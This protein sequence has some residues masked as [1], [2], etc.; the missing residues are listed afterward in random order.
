MCKCLQAEIITLF[1]VFSMFIDVLHMTTVTWGESKE[2]YMVGYKASIFT[3]SVKMLTTVH[4]GYTMK[5]VGLKR[6]LWKKSVDF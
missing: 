4:C 2:T 6:S 3:S 5:L 1:W